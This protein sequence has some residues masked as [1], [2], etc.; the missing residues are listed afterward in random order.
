MVATTA[1]GKME[2]ADGSNGILHHVYQ[3]LHAPPP[4]HFSSSV[5]VRF[6][7]LHFHTTWGEKGSPWKNH[8]LKKCIS[9]HNHLKSQWKL[10]K[11]MLRNIYPRI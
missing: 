8:T 10:L 2:N 4:N 9:W 11:S 3:H 6:L 7:T 5:S 1:S